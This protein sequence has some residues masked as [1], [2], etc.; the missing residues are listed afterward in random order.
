MIGAV[1][2]SGGDIAL[3]VTGTITGLGAF[4]GSI[5][6]YR[7]SRSAAKQLQG[8]GQGTHT[9]MM[10]RVLRTTDDTNKKLDEHITKTNEFRE[11]TDERFDYTN[12]MLGHV[13]RMLGAG[14]VVV[15]Q[16]RDKIH[17][18]HPSGGD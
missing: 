1:D 12:M 2:F 7:N 6:A 15:N 17:H 11:F 14:E 13:L 10:E 8:N 4:V 16:A 18:H 3:L 9:E 5:A